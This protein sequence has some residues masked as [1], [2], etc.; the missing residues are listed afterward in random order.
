MTLSPKEISE[1]LRPLADTVTET[2]TREVMRDVR[3]ASESLASALRQRAPQRANATIGSMT[4]TGALRR[5][6]GVIRRASRSAAILGAGA[7]VAPD[8]TLWAQGAAFPRQVDDAPVSFVRREVSQAFESEVKTRLSRTVAAALSARRSDAPLE[9]VERVDIDPDELATKINRF[10][11]GEI[12]RVVDVASN[13]SG[14]RVS[15]FGVLAEARVYGFSEYRFTAIIDERTT[16]VCKAMDGRIFKVEQTYETLSRVL[17]ISDPSE[18]KEKAPFPP[19]GEASILGLREMGA[20]ELQARGFAAPPLHFLCRSTVELVGREVARDAVDWSAIPATVARAERIAPRQEDALRPASRAIFGDVSAREAY[21]QGPES[22]AAGAFSHYSAELHETIN[23][24]IRRRRPLEDRHLR[25][26]REMDRAFESDAAVLDR[27]VYVSRGVGA[28]LVDRLDVGATFEDAAF[29][30]TSLDMGAAT[31]FADKS[32]R[33]AVL[34]ILVPRGQ[35]AIYTAPVSNLPV[36][37]EVVLPRGT[38]IRVLGSETIVGDDGQMRTVYK[39]MVVGRGPLRDPQSAALRG[40]S[41]RTDVERFAWL[42]GD[43]TSIPLDEAADVL[44]RAA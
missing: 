3:A 21:E 7:V 29:V 22:G 15:A 39:V 5:S 6:E 9:L 16:E 42:D 35:R 25:T 31:A 2:V 1:A 41:P 23:A 19:G 28:G 43:L 40:V 37:R 20:E 34:S 24:N 26:V 10:L 8:R 11:R 27:D 14:T 32:A 4:L 13:L 12:R 17:Q 38:Q 18:L 33:G 44:G 36:E 30:S